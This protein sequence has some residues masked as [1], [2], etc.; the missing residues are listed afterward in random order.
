MTRPADFTHLGHKALEVAGYSGNPQQN[1]PHGLADEPP[2]PPAPKA[3]L[4]IG[5]VLAGGGAKGA[6]ELGV[7]DYMAEMGAQVSAIAGTSIGALNGA[8]LASK[9]SFFHG[10]EQLARFWERFA[11]RMGVAPSE[12]QGLPLDAAG[13]AVESTARQ[14]RRLGPRLVALKHRLTLLEELVDEAVDAERIRTGRPLWVAAYPLMDRQAVP[15]RLRHAVEIARWLGGAR[16]TIIRLN[17][18]PVPQIREAVLASAALPFVFPTRVIDGCTYLDGALGRG[19]GTPVRAFAEKEHCDVLVVVHLHPDARVAPGAAT[20]L[21]RVDIRPSLPIIPP[22][23]LGPLTGL[24]AFSPERVGALRA[25]GYRDAA[26]RFREIEH[27]LARRGA[28]AEAES[29]MLSSL[30]RMRGEPPP[31]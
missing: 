29:A 28:L 6:Y 25:L 13:V 20:G 26:A 24:M 8:V 19:D 22:G 14:L 30:R 31:V 1:T 17:D 12:D 5:L 11:T 15:E 4:R 21:V 10:V 16:A 2:A 23:P 27:V 18:L 3:P 9:E 7:L